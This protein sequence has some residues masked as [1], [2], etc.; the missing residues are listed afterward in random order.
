MNKSQ[1]ILDYL[2]TC[3]DIS[4][5]PLYFNFVSAKDGTKQLMTL[6][7]DTVIETPYIDGTVKKRYQ[8]T[9]VDFRSISTNPVVKLP[10]FSNENIVD[11]EDVQHLIDWINNQDMLHNYPDFG[12]GCEVDR[13]STT[14]SNPRLDSIDVSVSPPL[15]R[16]SFTITIDYLDSSNK[17]WGRK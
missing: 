5:S 7:N 12:D 4:N 13:I 8:I 6:S 11:L 14:T 1:A 15:A 17:V 2:L 10:G 16:Y 9:I 3:E